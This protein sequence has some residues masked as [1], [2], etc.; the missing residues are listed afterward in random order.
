MNYL[1]SLH[2]D[3]PR[4]A[5]Q[6]WETAL[7]ELQLQTT[8]ATF[9]TWIK[10][11]FAISY[12]EGS[13]MVGV[14]NPYAQQWLEKRLHGMIERTVSHIVGHATTVEFII[15]KQAEPSESKDSKDEDDP[16]AGDVLTDLI[17]SPLEPYIQ[18]QK[19]AIRFWQPLIGSLSFGAWQM[20]RCQDKSNLVKRGPK[21][22]IS[23]DLLALTLDCNRQSLTGRRPQQKLEGAFGVLNEFKI[24]RIDVIGDGR[25]CIYW[26]R[27]MNALPLLSPQQVER[28]PELIRLQHELWLH[29]F[30][31][32][33]QRWEQLSIPT[34]IRD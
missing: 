14:R 33:T 34:L 21:H 2:D 26:A 23:V 16:H 3:K 30:S 8:H 22:K 6:I 7:S 24:A 11:T 32:D 9:D 10:P 27:T 1:N 13:M 28:L 5:Q 17:D 15:K 29:D 19:Y 18:V 25:G 4:S 12:T 20:L 31:V